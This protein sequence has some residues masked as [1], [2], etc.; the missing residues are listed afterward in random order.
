MT[1][2][3]RGRLRKLHAGVLLPWTRPPSALRLDPERPRDPAGV[4]V[5][6]AEAVVVRELFAQYLAPGGSLAGLAKRLYTLGVPTPMGK[7]CWHPNTIRLILTNPAYTGQ[8][9]AGRRRTRDARLRW[10]A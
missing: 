7:R 3:R 8:V 10:S 4:R 6:E 9:Y 2:C 1:S 5:E